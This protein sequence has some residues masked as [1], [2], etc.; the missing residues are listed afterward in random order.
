MRTHRNHKTYSKRMFRWNIQP[1]LNK[2]LYT[3]YLSFLFIPTY[4]RIENALKSHAKILFNIFKM[5][6]AKQKATS[7]TLFNE[8]T[9][10]LVAESFCWRFFDMLMTDANI[11]NR[12]PTFDICHQHKLCP[13]LVTDIMKRLHCSR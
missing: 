12:S 5:I 6:L 8:I 7:A 9:L 1:S 2:I 13:K 3:I 4:M 10:M 11:E